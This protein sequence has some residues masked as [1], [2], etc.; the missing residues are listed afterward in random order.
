MYTVQ[1]FKDAV[2]FLRWE[3]KARGIQVKKMLH[4]V[5][6]HS[7]YQLQGLEASLKRQVLYISTK[8][9]KKALQNYTYLLG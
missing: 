8:N 3:R 9:M 5:R 1:K 7:A 6:I 2:D 4:K